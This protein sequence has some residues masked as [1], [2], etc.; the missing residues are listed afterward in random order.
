MDK[1]P[2]SSKSLEKHY[3]IDGNQFSQQYKE[4]LSDFT[5]WDQKS[6]AHKWMI[7]PENIGPNLS[8]DETALTNGELY[9]IIT[10]KAA[11]G[12]KGA[13][14]A[15]IQGTRSENIIS[16]LKKIPK[17]LRSIVE[18]V[19]LDMAGSMNKIVQKS[20]PMASRVIDRFHVQ[21]LAYEGLQEMRIA[22][23]WD[24]L[25]EES[26]AIREANYKE[27]KYQPVVFDNGDSKKQLLARSRYLLFKSANNWTKSQK[28][29]AEILF[30]QYP[31]IQEAY[32]LTHNLRLIFTQT[33]EKGIAYT[34]LAHWFRKVEES[35]FK[36]FTSIK[37]T[38]QNHYQGILNYFENRSTNA[39]AESFNA[40]LKAFR[41]SLRG[42]REI[43]FF[44]FR[45][46]KIYA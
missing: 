10:N 35:G 34:K 36:A 38:I 7:F 17:S 20:F 21:K 43:N 13:L 42:V 28:K 23:R 2:I 19:T 22:H 31:D 15:M 24:A 39:S 45:V 9:T 25:N 27:E 4:H 29:R 3:H 46:A 41:A 16:I 18:E 1:Y 8:I 37:N 44:L 6:H 11:K 12:Q 30:A 32:I 40:K 5:Q 14:V 33:K 26:K